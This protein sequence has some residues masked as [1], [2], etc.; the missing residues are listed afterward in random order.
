MRETAPAVLVPDSLNAL[1]VAAKA[2]NAS[3]I[4]EWLSL[5]IFSIF[6]RQ[7]EH[8]PYIAGLITSFLITDAISLRS[9]VLKL[10]LPSLPDSSN[11]KCSATS[12]PDNTNN[13][14]LEWRK[15]LDDKI[16]EVFRRW[17]KPVVI[18]FLFTV[19]E[20]LVHDELMQNQQMCLVDG[21]CSVFI[22][23]KEFLIFWI[24]Y[25]KNAGAALKDLDVTDDESLSYR[26]SFLPVMQILATLSAFAA[27]VPEPSIRQQ[28]NETLGKPLLT[29]VL[30][31]LSTCHEISTCN[32]PRWEVL[33][34]SVCRR[35]LLLIVANLCSKS[36]ENQREVGIQGG[37]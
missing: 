12:L 29:G 2:D 22:S 27:I 1:T 8:R 11:S 20:S 3:S 21:L 6:K 17:S 5:F 13:L 34:L 10:V 16:N 7:C 25:F 33:K 35:D 23:S 37:M 26:K 14:M 32:K 31:L 19:T 9:I 30:K 24:D 15:N 36:E 4:G 28:F 18:S